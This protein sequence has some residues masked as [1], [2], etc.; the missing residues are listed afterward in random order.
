MGSDSGFNTITIIIAIIIDIYAAL[1]VSLAEGP[2]VY[3]VV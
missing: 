3:L 2:S 1:P